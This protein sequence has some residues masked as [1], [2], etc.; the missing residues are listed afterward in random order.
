MGRKFALHGSVRAV[1]F[2]EQ[3]T[4][5]AAAA[6]VLLGALAGF[7]QMQL[8]RQG[9]IA[10]LAQNELTR[11]RATL[12][13]EN[14]AAGQP[15]GRSTSSFA[16]PQIRVDRMPVIEFARSTRSVYPPLLP[17]PPMHSSSG[18]T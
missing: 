1:L 13:S 5:I 4:L 7:Q 6:S 8:Y 3:T 17:I 2:W 9:Q 14:S 15:G 18:S 16:N 10:S 12:D 11:L